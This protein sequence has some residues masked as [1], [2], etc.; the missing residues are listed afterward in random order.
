VETE[1][2]AVEYLHTAYSVRTIAAG[3]V[4]VSFDIPG[5]FVKQAAWFLEIVDRPGVVLKSV[6]AIETE[7]DHGL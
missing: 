4:R 7:Q 6:T 1:I 3:G 5:Q 2:K